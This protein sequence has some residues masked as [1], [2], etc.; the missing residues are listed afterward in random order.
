MTNGFQNHGIENED[1]QLLESQEK[2]IL[3][4]KK[5]NI[6]FTI[7]KIKSCQG[8][9]GRCTDMMLMTLDGSRFMTMV[10]PYLVRHCSQRRPAGHGG[11]CTIY[12]IK[13]EF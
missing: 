5:E 10:V 12:C 7:D 3:V 6:D 8:H 2:I 4:C 13:R 9:V 1:I 11:I